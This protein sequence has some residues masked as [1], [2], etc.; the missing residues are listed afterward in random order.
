MHCYVSE[1]G[2][3]DTACLKLHV[4]NSRKKRG[5]GG[6]REGRMWETIN[7]IEFIFPYRAERQRTVQHFLFPLRAQEAQRL[8]FRF[9]RRL[10]G[11]PRKIFQMSR[12][13]RDSTPRQGGFSLSGFG[14]GGAKKESSFLR[15]I[16][17]C[18]FMS[19]YREFSSLSPT[20]KKGE[21]K[22]RLI[23]AQM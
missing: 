18:V 23:E 4:T 19:P 2:G 8:F 10:Y 1:E 7:N 6:G 22:S 14:E 3:D 11:R 5:V 16:N 15:L 12:R 13:S 9:L 17:C 20:Q 21:S